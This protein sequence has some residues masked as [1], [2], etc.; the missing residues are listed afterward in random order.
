VYSRK[1]L[2]YVIL[3]SKSRLTQLGRIRSSSL[4]ECYVLSNLQKIC[5]IALPSSSKPSGSRVSKS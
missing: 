3:V 2:M 1:F 5:M 4:T